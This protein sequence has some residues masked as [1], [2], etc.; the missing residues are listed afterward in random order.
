MRMKIDWDKILVPT[1]RRRR[2]KTN[3]LAITPKASSIVVKTRTMDQMAE[4]LSTTLAPK[5]CLVVVTEVSCAVLK[6]CLV[7]RSP[8]IF[9]PRL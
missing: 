5:E 8:R 3:Q 6:K 1:V 2:T 4:R 7:F 9:D